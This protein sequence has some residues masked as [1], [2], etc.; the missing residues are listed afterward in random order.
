MLSWLKPILWA[1]SVLLRTFPYRWTSA[2]GA[3]A[4]EFVFR[5]LRFRRN[6]VRENLQR[7]FP[8][9]SDSQILDVMA[10][11]YRNYGRILS[12]FLISFSWKKEDYLKNVQVQ[13]FEHVQAALAQGRGVYLLSCHMASWELAIGVVAA[14][15]LPL[16]VIV[17]KA[18]NEK[19]ERL[20]QWYRKKTGAEIFWESGSHHQ[21][22]RSLKSGRAVT[23]ILDQ[24]MGPP[25]GLPVRFFGETAG[26]A[27]SLALFMERHEA[28]V[29]LAHA[30]REKNGKLVTIFSE[31]FD[32]NHLGK[33]RVE[34]MYQ[35][36]QIFNDEIEKRVRDYPEQWLWLHRRWKAF[37]GTPRWQLAKSAVTLVFVFFLV[38]CG[39][40]EPESTGIEIPKDE[41]TL[42]VP[43]FVEPAIQEEKEL[44]VQSI[45]SYRK[46]E[47][48][49]SRISEEKQKEL[50]REKLEK[51]KAERKAKMQKAKAASKKVYDVVPVSRVPFQVGE[52]QV[53]ALRWTAIPA[54]KVT[55]EVRKGPE[56]AGRKTLQLWGNV[57]SSRLVDAIYHVDNTIE[58][59][60]D[61]EAL[62]PYKFLLH[63]VESSQK[64]E[65]KV[66]MD[67]QKEKAYYW[68]QRVSEKWGNETLKNEDEMVGGTQDMFSGLFFVRTLDYELGKVIKIPVYEKGK[69]MDVELKAVAK[70]VVHTEAGVFQAWKV[71]TKVYLNNQLKMTGDTFMW[72]SDDSNRYL[73]KFDAKLK[74]GSLVGTLV[75]AREGKQ[76]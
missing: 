22:L 28:P 27:A 47:A 44:P 56:I 10:K 55:L 5:V 9:F 26:T 15:G 71:L 2:A 40:L 61:Q 76:Q 3:L 8:Q 41:N 34:R 25:I 66:I 14:S 75:S 49:K 13:G 4:G 51:L 21:I 17:K 38:S 43:A 58:S 16:D 70:E 62:I 60:V 19:V 59:F 53:L 23:F 12:D 39:T 33:T 7:A 48:E 29:V 68:S 46:A 45:E 11:N 74:F 35:R 37:K 52:R 1:I 73:V 63:M 67:H 32:F 24:F 6:V 30:H 64:K 18:K 65:T 20:L 42:E 54:G 31:P 50:A 36:T 72:I 57:L 69:N